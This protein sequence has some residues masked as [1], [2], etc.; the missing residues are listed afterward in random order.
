MKRAIAHIN[1]QHTNALLFNWHNI[2]DFFKCYVSMHMAKKTLS[3]SVHCVKVLLLLHW[4]IIKFLTQ[5][6]AAVWNTMARI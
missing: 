3:L 4:L 5:S 1:F 2:S 6:P